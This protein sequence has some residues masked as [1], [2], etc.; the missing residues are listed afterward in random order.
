MEAFETRD[1]GDDS[2]VMPDVTPDAIKRV[3]SQTDLPP[4]FWLK[5]LDKLV[6]NKNRL[7]NLYS[8]LTRFTSR[9]G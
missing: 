7:R 2:Q 1:F 4:I 3:T 6:P 9:A 5:E 8:L